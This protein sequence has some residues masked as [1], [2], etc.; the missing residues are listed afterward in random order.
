M[1]GMATAASRI[2]RSRKWR[3]NLRDWRNAIVTKP[4]LLQDTGSNSF[5]NSLSGVG[6]GHSGIFLGVGQIGAL[7]KHTTNIGIPS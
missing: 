4:R 5:R 3:P 1:R 7:A 2:F 6:I